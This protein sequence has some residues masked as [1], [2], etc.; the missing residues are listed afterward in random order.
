MT[1]WTEREF[2]IKLDFL[3]EGIY[4]LTSCTDGVNANNYPPDYSIT[5]SL[6]KRGD[7]IHVKMAQGGGFLLRLVKK[8]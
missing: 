6:I 2:D 8:E 1:D 5:K 4:Q 7:T 3:Q